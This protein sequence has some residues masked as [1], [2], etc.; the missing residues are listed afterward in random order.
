MNRLTP[1]Q[2]FAVAIVC[3]AAGWWAMR[4]PASP[5]VPE[6]PKDRPFLKFVARVAR[7]GLWVAL[8]AEKAPSEAEQRQTIAQFDENGNRV[9]NHAEGW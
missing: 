3:V 4:S 5:F 9:L 7:L 6:K 2:A 1:R 8:A